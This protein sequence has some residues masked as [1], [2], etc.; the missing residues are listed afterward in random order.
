MLN[1]A[2][3]PFSFLL[4]K[5]CTGINYYLSPAGGAIMAEKEDHASDPWNLMQSKLTKGS[6]FIAASTRFCGRFL[7]SSCSREVGMLITVNGEQEETSTGI[8]LQ[9]FIAAHGWDPHTVVAELNRDIIASEHFAD[10]HLKAGDSLE[11]LHFVGG[12]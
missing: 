7:F 5:S 9:E 11:L 2:T 8:T 1:R 12:G 10:I 6:R 3:H 4:Q